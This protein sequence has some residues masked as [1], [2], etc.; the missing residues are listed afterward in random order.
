MVFLQVVLKIP[1][2]SGKPIGI[3]KQVTGSKTRDTGIKRVWIPNPPLT[4]CRTLDKTI[5]ASVSSNKKEL[6]YTAVHLSNKYSLSVYYVQAQPWCWNYGGKQ[7][8][9]CAFTELILQGGGGGR[10]AN[11]TK[12]TQ[13]QLTNINWEGAVKMFC[14]LKSVIQA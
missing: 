11:N 7:D 8:K 3:M 14:K 9:V 1:S 12:R 6:L 4:S 10:G 2:V 5:W 13:K